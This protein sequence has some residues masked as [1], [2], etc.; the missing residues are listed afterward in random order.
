MLTR[1]Q[2]REARTM[3]G[4]AG[5]DIETVEA[6]T[7]SEAVRGLAESGETI[8][9]GPAPAGRSTSSDADKYDRTGGSRRPPR[10]GRT[11][12]RPYGRRAA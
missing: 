11:S 7:G 5:V 10:R 3:F 2:L 12:S 9:V 4:R 8:V 1:D 6:S